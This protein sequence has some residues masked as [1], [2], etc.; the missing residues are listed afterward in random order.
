MIKNCKNINYSKK[1]A[2]TLAE[3]L[4]TLLIV[5]VLIS[6][7]FGAVN[8][9]RP[10]KEKLMFLKSYRAVESAIQAAINDPYRYE[11]TYYSESERNFIP[12][13]QRHS[14]FRDKP[15]QDYTVSIK[16]KTAS[17]ISQES[18]VCWHLAGYM[19]VLGEVNC[20]DNSKMN[21]KSSDGVCFYNWFG[22]KPDGSIT[23]E[24]S[25]LCN[26][27]RYEVSVFHNGNVTV[28][29]SSQAYEWMQNQ[30]DIKK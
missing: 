25:P 20:A 1:S 28:L 3:T 9:A 8:L 21:F 29:E 13:N 15:Y 4:L 22:V 10:D 11:Q 26:D 2:F 14:D 27:K 12:E 17:G 7:M 23:G 24:I 16:G 6:L 18:A 19:N 30:S 5:G